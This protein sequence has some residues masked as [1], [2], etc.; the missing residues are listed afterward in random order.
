MLLSLWLDPP[1][2]S[3]N[4]LVF[5]ICL[6][7]GQ[8]LSFILISLFVNVKHFDVSSILY[9]KNKEFNLENE[10]KIDSQSDLVDLS[11]D[12]SIK[13]IQKCVYK[14]LILS[15]WHIYMIL[16]IDVLIL[17]FDKHVSCHTSHLF[18][19][20]TWTNKRLSLKNQENRIK[21][22]YKKPCFW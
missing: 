3:T 15:Q 21:L 18:L 13:W 6:R 1:L 20:H 10:K 7:R 2:Y 17:F 9:F 22:F 19:Y 4:Y 8:V 12:L 5:G 11:G 14:Y 16:V